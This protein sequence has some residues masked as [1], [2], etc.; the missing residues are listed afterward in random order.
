MPFPTD[1]AKLAPHWANQDEAEAGAANRCP[2]HVL[3]PRSKET[4]NAGAEEAGTLNDQ[5]AP[6]R[7]ATPRPGLSEA[8]E[9]PLPGAW[10]GLSIPGACGNRSSRTLFQGDLKAAKDSPELVLEEICHPVSGGRQRWSCDANFIVIKGA[11]W[12]PLNRSS[13]WPSPQLFPVGP[14][15]LLIPAPAALSSLAWIYD[16]CPSRE[17]SRTNE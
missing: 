6:R 9:R 12:D 3:K 8:V 17:V 11:G 7:C 14:A 13:L 16:S 5:S 4:E 1:P 2:A 15:F 10:C